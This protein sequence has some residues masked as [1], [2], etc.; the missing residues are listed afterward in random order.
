MKIIVATNKGQNKDNDF[1]F[2]NEGEFVTFGMICRKD[3][4]NPDGGCG[5]GRSFV[6]VD[7][8]LATTTAAVAETDLTKEELLKLYLE[9]EKKAGWS[10][11]IKFNTEVI[12]EL[13]S[14]ASNY[15]IGTI[16]EKR[17]EDIKVRNF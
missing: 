14:I 3:E 5:C 6:G 10:E 11:N 17:L 8:R 7:T 4:Q 12:E 2:T 9:S 15:P 13:T 1:S 16:F